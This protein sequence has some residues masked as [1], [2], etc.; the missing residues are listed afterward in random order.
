MLIRERHERTG[1]LT[2]RPLTGEGKERR[3]GAQGLMPPMNPAFAQAVSLLI[4]VIGGKGSIPGL[5]FP[6]L[7]RLP[8]D[9]QRKIGIGIDRLL[10]GPVI[11]VE[12]RQELNSLGIP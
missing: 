2:H 10:V 7:P 5:S 8:W 9:S 3:K 6:F 1:P 11:D 12:E 4:V